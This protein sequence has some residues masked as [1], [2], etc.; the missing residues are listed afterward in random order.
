MSASP[1]KSVF[2][3][4]LSASRATDIPA[5]RLGWFLEA[6]RQG[7]CEWRNPFNNAR[8]WVSFDAARVIVFWS[9][10]FAPL[11][12]HLPLVEAH[13]LAPYFHFTVNDYEAEGFEPR[14]PPLS[15]RLDA[16]REL[17]ARYGRERV[18]WRFD[19]LLLSDALA[20]DALFRRA[21]ALGDRLHPYTSK[22]VFS[23]ADIAAYPRVARRCAAAASGIREFRA[24]E[25]AAFA[26]GLSAHLPRWGLEA[27]TCCEPDDL[28][29]HGIRHSACIDAQT[30]LR[31]GLL[32]PE[33]AKA[34][35]KKDKGQ[36]RDCRCTQ[37]KDIG[38]YRTCTQGC[39]YC[40]A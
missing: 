39:V 24:E 4:V 10:D 34:V 12:P 2:P 3:L 16:F 6:L 17:A 11:L 9:K 7:G 15:R 23:F 18:V 27:A 8:T 19:P 30:F 22:L 25:R 33:E 14:L 36:R 40:Y 32:T 31:L 29:A 20:P 1:V 21:V 37:S 38:A 35:S 28:S 26:Q 5:C 13:G